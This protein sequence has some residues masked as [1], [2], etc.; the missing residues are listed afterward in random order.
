MICDSRRIFKLTIIL[1]AGALA[2]AGCAKST[3][4]AAST[5]SPELSETATVDTELSMDALVV[6]DVS[7]ETVDG[8]TSIVGDGKAVGGVDASTPGHTALLVNL[9]YYSLSE[10]GL[11]DL[12]TGKHFP[13]GQQIHLDGGA[14]DR[15]L[16]EKFNADIPTACSQAEF[17]FAPS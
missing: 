3:P 13:F 8:C 12:R 11:T 15:H 5:H 6:G 14:V 9:K 2:V 7:I 10:D 1:V 16:A 17:F 4:T